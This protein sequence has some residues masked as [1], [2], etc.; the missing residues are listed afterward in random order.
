MYY[1][2]RKTLVRPISELGN[3]S[4]LLQRLFNGFLGQCEV[5]Y[6]SGTPKYTEHEQRKCEL[7]Q[8][9]HQFGFYHALT[10]KSVCN[11]DGLQ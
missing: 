8:E 5:R 4:V 10:E 7:I 11:E 1:E 3:A 2:K 6:L 9:L